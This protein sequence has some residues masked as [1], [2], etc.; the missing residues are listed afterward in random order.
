MWLTSGFDEI[1]QFA[2]SIRN[3]DFRRQYFFAKTATI[4]EQLDT[5]SEIS[6]GAVISDIK[7]AKRT[8]SMSLSQ[9]FK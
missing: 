8:V 1:I 9:K 4:I 7:S 3:L 2:F 6:V 5:T